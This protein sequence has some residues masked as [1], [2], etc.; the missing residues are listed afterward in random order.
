MCLLLFISFRA[1]Q[2]SST[3]PYSCF[4]AVNTISETSCVFLC[5]QTVSVAH[6]HLTLS[7]LICHKLYSLIPLVSQPF[8]SLF[9]FDH[10][11]L[12][13]QFS[14]SLSVSPDRLEACYGSRPT[15]PTF[16]M[17]WDGWWS[18]DVLNIWGYKDSRTTIPFYLTLYCTNP[19]L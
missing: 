2:T 9:S 17:P 12:F 10:L 8:H 18:N 14:C 19:F 11:S 16:W 5:Y 4:L 15:C 13:Q 1:W 7:L 3:H 6:T